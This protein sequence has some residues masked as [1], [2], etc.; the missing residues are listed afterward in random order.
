MK[1]GFTLIELLAVLVLLGLLSLIIVPVVGK[2][3]TDNTEKIYQA[4]IKMIEQ[5]ARNWASN[6]VFSLPENV[7]ETLT[8][9]ICD[10]EKEGKIEVDMRNPKNEKLFYKDSVVIVTK[11]EYGYEYKY[12]ETSGTETAVCE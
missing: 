8:L 11:T 6:H 7:G 12:N 4:N 2:L 5:G 9:T 3:I 1:R 10:L